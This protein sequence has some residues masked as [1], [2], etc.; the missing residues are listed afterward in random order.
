MPAKTFTIHLRSCSESSPGDAAIIESIRAYL[1]AS[2]DMPDCTRS[3]AVRWA[4]HQVSGD[5]T[6][7]FKYLPAWWQM[8]R[9]YESKPRGYGGTTDSEDID[10]NFPARDKD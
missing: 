2:G 4:L 5:D 8:Y 7:I 1:I 6:P 3:D 9:V 10:P